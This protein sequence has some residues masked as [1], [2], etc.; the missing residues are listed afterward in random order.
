MTDP[1]SGTPSF[2]YAHLPAIL[3]SFML[4]SGESSD[5][6]FAAHPPG[7]ILEGLAE[8]LVDAAVMEVC[9][10]FDLSGF[11]VYPLPGDQ[12]AFVSAPRLGVPTPEVT[13]ADLLERSLFA[14]REGCCARI[15]LEK[16]LERVGHRLQDFPRTVVLDDLTVAMRAVMEGDGTSYMS[17][18]VVKDHLNSGRLVPHHV[19]GFQRERQACVGPHPAWA[20]R[21]RAGP[22]PGCPL[23]ALRHPDA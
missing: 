2:G 3:K 18:D 14:R 8:G 20:T 15:M 7:Q 17:L 11:T 16:N 4:Q 1:F 9:D 22:L 5:L 12:M 21:G 23:P 13:I 10:C 19:A 6:R